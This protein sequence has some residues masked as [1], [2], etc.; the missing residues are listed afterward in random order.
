[1]NLIV[2]GTGVLGRLLVRRLLDMGR[3]VRVMTRE[4][5]KAADLAGAGVDVVAG[6]LRDRASLVSA[7]RGAETVIA[8][9]HSFLGRGRAA[10]VHVDERGHRDLIDAARA[11]KPRRFVHLS[12]HGSG[13]GFETVPFFAIKRRVEQYLAGSGLEYTIVRATAFMEVHAHMLIGEPVLRGKT[14]RLIGGGERPRNFVAADDVAQ[15]VVRVLDDSSFAGRIVTIGG[16]GNPTPLEVVRLYERASGHTAKVSHLPLGAA[17]VIRRVIAP[18][19]PGIAQVI[20]AAELADT[21]DQT[22]DA[23][24][25]PAQLGFMPVGLEEWVMGRVAGSTRT[26]VS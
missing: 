26:A 6:D 8:A 7:C 19:H 17:R 1:M 9:A 18:V 10:S 4:P 11:A 15:A 3:P 14:V 25:V 20:Q 12:V 21:V 5:A 16:A 13:A 22:F 2:G 24:G 23:T